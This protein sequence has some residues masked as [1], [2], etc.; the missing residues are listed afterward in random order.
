MLLAMSYSMFNRLLTRN[1]TLT[2]YDIIPKFSMASN[3]TTFKK[4]TLKEM[5]E[6]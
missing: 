6:L 2:L 4:I 5:A 1:K 3:K